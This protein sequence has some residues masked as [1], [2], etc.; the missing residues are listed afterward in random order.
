M[1]L[2]LPL[3]ESRVRTCSVLL[4]HVDGSKLPTKYSVDVPSVGTVKDLLYAL[5]K[6]RKNGRL[7]RGLIGQL[8]GHAQATWSAFF[9]ASVKTMWAAWQAF[10]RN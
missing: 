10:G 7:Q 1:Y 8:Q 4:I 3:P 9:L 5:A 2:S 6:V